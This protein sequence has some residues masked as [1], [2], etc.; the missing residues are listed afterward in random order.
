MTNSQASRDSAVMTS[1]TTPSAKYSC[2]RSPLHWDPGIAQRRLALNLDR[3]ADRVDDAGELEEQAVARGFDDTAPMLLDLG[4]GQLAVE[5]RESTLLVR[6]HQ[7]RIAR[8]I[9]G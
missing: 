7:T 4:I 5:R 8:H 9:G 6:T 1:S 2:S 3:A